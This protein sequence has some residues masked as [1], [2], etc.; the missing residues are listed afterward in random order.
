MRVQGTYLH[1]LARLALN[2]RNR[3]PAST[4]SVCGL[5]RDSS[6]G[7]APR[8][9]AQQ[10]PAESIATRASSRPG[11]PTPLNTYKNP[12]VADVARCWRH[13]AMAD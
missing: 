7:A 5:R 10:P 12:S 13:M 8:R 6:C 2:R 11:I 4:T 9:A 1:S 3:A